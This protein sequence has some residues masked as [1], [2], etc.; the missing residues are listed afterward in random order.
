MLQSHCSFCLHRPLVV[1]HL[2]QLALFHLL[3]LCPLREPQPLLVVL[4]ACIT[5][6][7]HVQQELVND[8]EW[9][10]IRSWKCLWTQRMKFY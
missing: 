7:H 3:Q 10:K 5:Y 9:R 8:C 1:F 4:A 2:I 6:S